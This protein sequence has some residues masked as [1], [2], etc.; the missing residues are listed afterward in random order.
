VKV[1]RGAADDAGNSFAKVVREPS[2]LFC[3]QAFDAFTVFETTVRDMPPPTRL[4]R[5][6]AGRGRL[7]KQSPLSSGYA[8]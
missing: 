7:K 6:K 3:F 8:V 2:S 5:K 1:D 4:S